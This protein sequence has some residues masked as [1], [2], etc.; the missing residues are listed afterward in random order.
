MNLVGQQINIFNTMK[1]R[2]PKEPASKQPG[3]MWRLWAEGPEG[4][5]PETACPKGQTLASASCT[6]RVLTSR[7]ERDP[8]SLSFILIGHQLQTQ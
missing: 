3:S 7:A 8:E 6:S 4:V 5:C 2:K 1:A